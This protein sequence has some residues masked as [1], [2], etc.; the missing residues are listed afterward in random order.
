MILDGKLL[1][2]ATK[3]I[4]GP[5]NYTWWNGEGPEPYRAGYVFFSKGEIAEQIYQDYPNGRP[6]TIT[7]KPSYV[8]E[9]AVIGGPGFGFYG[10]PPR[11]FP[12]IG[13]IV[14]GVDVEV[15]ANAT[16][17]RGAIGNTIIGNDVKI[18][19][20]V[21]VGHNARIGDRSI[22]TA[23]CVIGGSAVIGADCWI[24]LGAQV[25][26]YVSVGAGAVVGMGAIVVKDVPAGITV[27]GNPARILE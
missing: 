11:R 26:N 2:P 17:D 25:R 5:E 4:A 24:G 19:N 18:D 1:S 8:G 22:L 13:G 27:V 21:H 7:G 23:H 9:G 3:E 14:F 20:G 15:G 16:I 6:V 12:Q 10:D